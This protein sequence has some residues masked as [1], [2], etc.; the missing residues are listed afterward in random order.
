MIHT[1]EE[2][3]KKY[4]QHEYLDRL[5]HYEWKQ[6]VDSHNFDCSLHSSMIY[7]FQMNGV[8]SFIRNKLRQYIRKE[9]KDDKYGYIHFFID[10]DKIEEHCWGNAP[11]K[12]WKFK[13]DVV[14]QIKRYEEQDL[15]EWGHTDTPTGSSD[16]CKIYDPFYSDQED[17]LN[18]AD[19][20]EN[21]VPLSI[22]ASVQGDLYYNEEMKDGLTYG[23][24]YDTDAWEQIEIVVLSNEMAVF[25]ST[26]SFITRD[27]RF[28]YSKPNNKTEEEAMDKPAVQEKEEKQVYR[29]NNI[30][31]VKISMTSSGENSFKYNN[32]LSMLFDVIINENLEN[33]EI[34]FIYPSIE[35]GITKTKYQY[36]VLE[37]S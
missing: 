1:Q 10:V 7:L 5:K 18:T 4:E 30:L 3:S 19:E 6:E 34:T 20:S 9:T 14:T 21:S 35:K 31:P 13:E 17:K 15:Y 8:E 28:P 25:V 29:L 26:W 11:Y 33:K 16:I 36:K 12:L 27:Y 22:N 37:P 2:I 24:I 23:Q 32:C